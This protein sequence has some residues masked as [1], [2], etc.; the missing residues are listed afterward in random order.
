MTVLARGALPPLH[1]V[2]KGSTPSDVTTGNGVLV[3]LRPLSPRCVWGGEGERLQRVKEGEV[4]AS[5]FLAPCTRVLVCVLTCSVCA[6][7]KLKHSCRGV[8][9]PTPAHT[10]GTGGGGRPLGFAF[11]TSRGTSP[12]LPRETGV[13]VEVPGRGLTTSGFPP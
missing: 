13:R 12:S 2:S 7:L 11:S 3:S 9:H 6:S 10:C 5:W 1:V 8:S 4:R